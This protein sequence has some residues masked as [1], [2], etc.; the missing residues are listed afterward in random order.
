MKEI[1][2]V[3]TIFPENPSAAAFVKVTYDGLM[4]GQNMGQALDGFNSVSN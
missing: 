2:N 4:H 1:R 3:Q